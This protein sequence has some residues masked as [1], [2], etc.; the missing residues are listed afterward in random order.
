MSDAADDDLL[1]LF[2]EEAELQIAQ[3]NDALIALEGAADPQTV[4]ENLMRAAHSLKGAA[5]IVGLSPLVKLAHATEDLFVAAMAGQLTV[6]AAAV[7][8][9]LGVSD[10]I[11]DLA[12]GGTANF[13]VRAPELPKWL[14]RLGDVRAGRHHAPAA[15]PAAPGAQVTLAQA[16]PATGTPA[17][18]SP[19]PPT[20]APPTPAPPT[21]APPAATPIADLSLLELFREEAETQMAAMTVALVA[22]ED[23]DD[24]KPELESLMRAAHSMKGAA[25]IVGIDP[26]VKL[27]HTTEDL[28]VAALAGAV[29]I[30]PPAVDVVFAVIDFIADISSGDPARMAVAPGALEDL[31]DR[32]GRARRG[33]L[34]A[35]TPAPAVAPTPPAAAAAPV[36]VSSAPA[37]PVSAPDTPSPARR[38]DA[39]RGEVGASG[40]SIRMTAEALERLTGLAAE[41]VVESERLEQ[42]LDQGNGLRHA[43]RALTSALDTLQEGLRQRTAGPAEKDADPGTAVWLDSNGHAEIAALFAARDL[44]ERQLSAR[45]AALE[46]YSRRS[47]TIARRLSRESMASRMMPFGSILRGFPRL[48]RDICRTLGKRCR[49]LVEGEETLVDRE[50]LE[51]LEAPLNHII[52]N[53]LDHGLELPEVREAAGKPAEGTLR[54][55]AFHRAGRLQIVVRDDGRGINTD[56]LRQRIVDRA[57]ESAEKAALL[58]PEELYEFLFLPGFS[59]A[60]TVTELSGRGV[61]LDAVRTMVQSSGGAVTIQSQL[62]AGSAFVIELPVTRS[63]TRALI[64][65]I[66]GEPYALPTASVQ[67]VL[68]LPR[69]AVTTLEGRPCFEYAGMHVA[70]ITAG[71]ILELPEAQHRSD[72]LH[73]V[74]LAAGDRRYG[75]AVDGFEGERSLVVRRLDERLGEVPDVAAASTDET[76]RVI[77]ILNLEELVG[78]I[79]ALINGGRRL[80][81]TAL[82]NAPER[83]RKR[84]L[85][86]D[87]SLTVRE[88]ERQLLASR[89]YAVDV[90]VDGLE[91][92]SAVRLGNYDLVVSDVDMP[93]MNGIE[94]VRRIRADALLAA[95]PVVIVSY[96][97]R[98]EDRLRGLEAG[99]TQY[100]TKGG[101]KDSMLVEAVEDLIGAA[102]ATGP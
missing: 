82:A 62:G 69:S 40:R 24:P 92:W 76:G 47:S 54:V 79:D 56:S 35:S 28:F 23:A 90:A 68:T 37:E 87:D 100:L 52:R 32:L 99:A 101:F 95:L 93:R 70:I 19:A 44:L 96:K 59:T 102:E 20:P 65:T 63:V 21:P 55:Q 42:L 3:L 12:S 2:K 94:L 48:V 60:P 41:A 30:T 57:L 1:A 43:Q 58:S 45:E 66:G 18:T 10:F 91:G 72:Q 53:G 25:R 5:Q 89:G 75:L 83:H 36:D 77:L 78:S 6:D 15:P 51:Q 27:A 4:L 86:V 50:I 97:D 61:G 46:D 74:L 31:Q 9:L 7:D 85:V 88:T 38:T 64:A 39:T 26:L 22:L 34:E 17:S 13:N 49:F 71:E 33:E 98:E 29:R 16:S 14:E 80:G 84:I 81:L 11:A 8:V 73:I 67:R